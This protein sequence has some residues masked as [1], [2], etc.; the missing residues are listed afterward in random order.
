MPKKKRELIYDDIIAPEDFDEKRMMDAFEA[1]DEEEQETFLFMLLRTMK[2][3]LKGYQ[4]DFENI[5][6]EFFK[7][8]IR[9][10]RKWVAM[11]QNGCY[12]TESDKRI[13]DVYWLGYYMGCIDLVSA[14]APCLTKPGEEEKERGISVKDD[15]LEHFRSVLE[16]E[17]KSVHKA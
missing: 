14:T 6:K 10:T 16:D 2:D 12:K 5:R 15:L 1:M 4:E 8:D 3:S 17:R 7:G 13:L 9:R 11:L